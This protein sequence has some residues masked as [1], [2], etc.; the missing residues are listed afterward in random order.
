[1][2]NRFIL[3]HSTKYKKRM[4]QGH[5]SRFLIPDWWVWLRSETLGK[6][7]HQVKIRYL[8]R[9][10][11]CLGFVPSFASRSAGGDGGGDDYARPP[12]WFGPTRQSQMLRSHTRSR[13]GR[14]GNNRS[15]PSSFPR[16]LQQSEK[17]KSDF[18]LF[19]HTNRIFK[20]SVSFKHTKRNLPNISLLSHQSFSPLPTWY[21]K[22]TQ[23]PKRAAKPENKYPEKHIWKRRLHCYFKG[24]YCDGQTW[25]I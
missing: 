25:Q 19:I 9:Q 10:K 17:G 14:C 15:P 20:G 2:K 24:A 5:R 7:L 23:L 21:V 1:M 3:I 11:K 18:I 6:V 13:H 22:Q 16:S 8:R 12:S 4:F